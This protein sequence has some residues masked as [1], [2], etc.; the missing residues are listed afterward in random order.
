MGDELLGGI[1]GNDAESIAKENRLGQTIAAVAAAS[2]SY[3][4][5]RGD[6]FHRFRVA[7][8]VAILFDR[9]IRISFVARAVFF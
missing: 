8:R 4:R 7:T 1:H 9:P 6:Y 3:A 5:D 2:N